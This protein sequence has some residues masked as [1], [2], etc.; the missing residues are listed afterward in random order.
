MIVRARTAIALPEDPEGSVEEDDLP[1]G[2]MIGRLENIAPGTSKSI[3]VK[4]TR[5]A[6]VLLCNISDDDDVVD[7]HFAEGMRAD[8]A[9]K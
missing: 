1:A 2:T 8:F 4:L 3:T 6:Y 7:S 9:V 5:G